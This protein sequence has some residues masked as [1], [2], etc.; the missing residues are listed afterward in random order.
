MTF[1]QL[2]HFTV[3]LAILVAASCGW[4]AGAAEGTLQAGALPAPWIDGTDC[5]TEPSVHVHPYNDD[6]FML[7][8]SLCTNVE[9]PFI[10]LL[11]G[12]HR[13]LMQDTGAANISLRA[14]V[15]DIITQWL[16]AH[17]R[18][19]IELI[20]SHSH[21]HGDHV[22]GDRQFL[23]RPNTQV[24]GYA[25][26]DVQAFF[27]I[28]NWPTEIV[29]FDLG[30]GRIVDVIP[31]PG[32]QDAHIALYDRRTGLLFTGDSLY[33]GRLYFP[34]EAFPL[35]RA[36]IQ[37]LLVFTEDKPVRHILGTHL[38]MSA[39][40]G[41][42]FLPQATH[43]PNEH[44]LELARSHLVELGTA[45]VAMGNDPKH[46]KHDD[47][48][49][50]PL[51]NVGPSAA[52]LTSRLTEVQSS[53]IFKAI[54]ELIARTPMSAD[55]INNE[56][57]DPLA[58]LILTDPVLPSTVHDLLAALNTHNHDPEGV[59]VQ[60]VYVVSETG[61]ILV[62]AQSQGLERRERAVITRTRGQDAIVMIAP[63]IRGGASLL[64]VMAWDADKGAFNYYERD[65]ERT[66]LW[67]GDSTHALKVRSRGQGCFTCHMNGAPIM[68]ALRAPWTNWHTQDATIKRE[69]IPEDSPLKHDP[70]FFPENLTKAEQLENHIKAW[71]TKTNEGHLKRLLQ[72]QI[73]TRTALRSLFQTTTANLAFSPE[74]SAGSGPIV[75][76]PVS[77]FINAQGFENAARLDILMPE[78]FGHCTPVP[79]LCKPAVDRSA[80]QDALEKFEFALKGPVD[81]KRKPGDTH[82]AFA[83]PEAAY[84]DNDM[85][86]QLVRN[87]IVSSRFAACTLAVDFPNPV[88]S[89]LREQLFSFVP[90]ATLAELGVRDVSD[91]V[92]HAIAHRASELPDGHAEREAPDQFLA[93]WKQ[94]GEDW[95]TTLPSRID[96]YLN[97]VATRLNTTAGFFDYVKL[98]EARRKQFEKSSH[99]ALKESALLFPT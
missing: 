73:D 33:P 30:G 3:I 92:A 6:L 46:E 36:S 23:G 90:Q 54:D 80:Y 87:G 74:P 1:L 66:W 93:C 96:T 89:A 39:Q 32:H 83:V 25:P 13:V 75:P 7:R 68:K 59:P 27:G 65:G 35:Y 78:A 47:F 67:K 53:V 64:E 26:S 41:V 71:V 85:I 82:F 29:T 34:P 18:T 24:V 12:E 57:H 37:R 42:D 51:F 4:E 31:L 77:C 49:I 5:N 2:R 28:G 91:T 58:R 8:Q 14:V 69:A 19:A 61:Q 60:E 62:K 63:S 48:V 15:D 10:Y 43:H 44:R 20:V 99:A 50:F 38:E 45:L 84:E 9:A 94:P 98:S 17:G 86:Q 72:N 55:E 88:Y 79:S 40:P 22:A 21:S 56:L 11:F 16:A 76:I 70:L 97:K 52:V 81:F 95:K